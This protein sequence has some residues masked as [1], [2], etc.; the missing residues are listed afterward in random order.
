MP[1]LTTQE[2]GF[3]RGRPVPPT[4]LV[5]VPPY[6]APAGAWEGSVAAT[7]SRCPGREG[8]P[9]CVNGLGHISLP[10]G[11]Q[12]SGAAQPFGV[13]L[14]TGGIAPASLRNAR[15]TPLSRV[16]GFCCLAGV[17]LLDCV[18]AHLS[19]ADSMAPGDLFNEPRCGLAGLGPVALEYCSC[20]WPW[21]AGCVTPVRQTGDNG[22]GRQWRILERTFMARRP[23]KSPAWT[24]L[25]GSS[26]GT[27]PPGG[28]MT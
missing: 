13:S 26:Q 24:P 16:A 2:E 4:A 17:L 20:Y 11:G 7:W 23:Q 10:L 3:Q 19:L 21:W 6:A 28:R 8:V 22:N 15:L 5:Q 25:E 1:P 14:T 9:T 27:S 12:L 18:P